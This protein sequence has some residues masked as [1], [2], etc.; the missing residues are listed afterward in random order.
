MGVYPISRHTHIY[1]EQCSISCAWGLPFI[2]ATLEGSAV[3]ELGANS[4]E[5]MRWLLQAA[6]FF[7]DTSFHMNFSFDHHH[8]PG[9]S[10]YSKHKNGYFLKQGTPKS[11]G[12]TLLIVF[13]TSMVLGIRA[14]SYNIVLARCS[15]WCCWSV[16]PLPPGSVRWCYM[17]NFQD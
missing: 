13:E 4:T 15:S 7:P 5:G 14:T 12:G 1:L 16:F 8:V 11:S 6:C 17:E 2:L 10:F 9:P 3:T